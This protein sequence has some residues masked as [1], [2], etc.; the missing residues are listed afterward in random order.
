VLVFV[1]MV[2][3]AMIVVMIMLVSVRVLGVIVM[4][5]VAL[6]VERL[7]LHAGDNH[8]DLCRSDAIAVDT[9]S[10]KFRP[11][12]QGTS[13]LLEQ[14]QGNTGV[15]QGSE[16]HIAADARETVNIS[17]A[18]GQDLHTSAYPAAPCGNLHHRYNRAGGQ[19]AICVLVC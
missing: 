6:Q 18:H 5:M 16:Q 14:F 19:T 2:M 15:H 13:G 8:I 10:G 1:L 3:V 12:I 4:M 7:I 9:L 11:K 17:N